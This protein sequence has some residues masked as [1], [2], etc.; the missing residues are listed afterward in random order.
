MKTQL[1]TPVGWLEISAIDQ[2][3]TRIDFVRTLTSTPS[4]SSLKGTGRHLSQARTQL[5]EYFSGRRRKFTLRLAPQGTVFQKKV[6]LALTQIPYGKTLSYKEVASRIRSPR[7]VRAVG[8]ANGRNPISIVIPC[9]RVIASGG[10]L[11]GYSGG[12]GLP[13]KRRLLN[14]EQNNG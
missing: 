3:I 7:A 11:G 1:K 4:P 2:G 13:T 9:H 12:N 6:W 14:H 5:V 10:G 8:G